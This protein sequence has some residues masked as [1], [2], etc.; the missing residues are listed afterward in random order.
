MKTKHHPR[1]RAVKAW[2]DMTEGGVW[3]VE[4]DDP[5]LTMDGHYICRTGPGE[6][7][8]RLATIITSSVSTTPLALKS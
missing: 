3:G 1:M 4:V 7:G 6:L 8:E 5:R 2:I